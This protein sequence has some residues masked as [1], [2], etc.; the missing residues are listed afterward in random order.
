MRRTCVG[1]IE[2]PR[3]FSS[4]PVSGR[5][6]NYVLLICSDSFRRHFFIW[7]ALGYSIEVKL[8]N[9]FR[10]KE[11][12]AELEFSNWKARAVTQ[13]LVTW[14]EAVGCLVEPYVSTEVISSHHHRTLSH[15]R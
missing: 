3:L 6:E 11:A 5:N 1:L 4:I 2:I 10:A 9:K 7:R 15:G 8:F 12:S 13:A 14:R